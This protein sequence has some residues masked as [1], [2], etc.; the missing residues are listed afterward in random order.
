[1][2]T[3]LKCNRLFSKNLFMSIRHMKKEIQGYN[4]FS[5]FA[6]SNLLKPV[7]IFAGQGSSLLL[8][9]QNVHSLNCL[10][11]FF[12]IVYTQ[13]LVLETQWPQHVTHSPTPWTNSAK[14]QAQFLLYTQI[15]VLK[16]TFFKTLHTILCFWHNF[17]AENIL[18][19]QGIHCHSNM[20]TDSS[21]GQ[22]PV[23]QF[24]N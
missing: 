20:H 15:A 7:Y 12:S 4:Y 16:H 23:T 22:T 10:L 24:Y 6:L 1:M 5:F 18:F 19:S 8:N 14:L 9:I 17:H 13:I 3:C 11:Q 2:K 21:Q